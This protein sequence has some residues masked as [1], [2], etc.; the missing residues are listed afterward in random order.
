[1]RE[2]RHL[3]AVAWGLERGSALEPGRT[4]VA[5][6]GGGVDHEVY[7]VDDR[8]FGRSVAKL[9][10]PRLVAEGEACGVLAREAAALQRLAAPGVVRCLDI[11]LR[12][13]HPH[14]L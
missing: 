5:R 9:V 12:G 10:R 6:L 14:L 2:R 7:A 4:V 13:G 3:A 1:M 8:R 11:D